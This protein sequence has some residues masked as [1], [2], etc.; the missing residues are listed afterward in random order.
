MPDGYFSKH[1]AWIRPIAKPTGALSSS[2]N[3][4]SSRNWGNGMHMAKRTAPADIGH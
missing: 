1:F 3:A 2:A 4:P